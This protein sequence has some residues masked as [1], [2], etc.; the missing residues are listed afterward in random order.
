MTR[1]A[2]GEAQAAGDHILVGDGLFTDFYEI[3]MLAGFQRQGMLEREATFDL[4]FRRA[5]FGGGYA[6]AAGLGPALEHLS[7]LR[8]TDEDLAYLDGPGVFRDDFLEYLRGWRFRGRIEAAPEGSIVFA[9]EPILTVSGA[10]GEA[11]LVETALLNIINFQTLIATKASRL[12]IAAGEG[13]IIEFGL[14]RA[15]GPDGGHSASRAAIIGGAQGSSNTAAGRDFGLEVVGTHAHAW[16]QAFDS[17]LAAFRAYADAFPDACTLLLDTYDTLRSGLPNAITVARELAAG[18]H[19]LRG[20]RL[21]SGDLAYLSRHVRAA[22]DEA[23]FP[24][25]RIVA[26]NDLDEDVIESVRRE[27]GRV[28]TYGVGTRLVTG[29]PAAALGGV[30]K[31]VDLDGQARMKL[32]ADRAKAVV[33]GRKRVWR[34]VS[35]D[36]HYALDVISLPDEQPAPGDW[37]TDPGNPLNRSRMAAG[38]SLEDLRTTVMLDGRPTINPEDLPTLQARAREGLSRLPEGSTR[39]LNPHVYRVGLSPRLHAL[40]NDLI[41][42]LEAGITDGQQPG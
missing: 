2:S 8:F 7:R 38:L 42:R 26:S 6:V 32:T 39:L 13:S 25:A 30:Y 24:D 3:A 27:G 40:R 19:R 21:D 28:D 11:Q 17:E 34:A 16:V 20:V 22:L 14:R 41:A 12:R 33:P 31:L 5:P 10:L 15:Q 35:E 9:K 4:Y 36:G 1:P 29:N 18:G 37:V 23:G